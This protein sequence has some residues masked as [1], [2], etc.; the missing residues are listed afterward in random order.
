[1]K[2]SHLIIA[3][4][5]SFLIASC[6]SND[7]SENNSNG[8]FNIGGVYYNTP[9]AYINDENTQTNA[10]SDLAIILSNKDLTPDEIASGI[11]IMYVDYSGV[12]FTT[13]AKD[14]LNYRITENASRSGGFITG[15]I[16][17]LEDN[18]GSNVN[19]TQISFTINAITST[20][21]DIEFSFTREDG[22]LITGSYSGNYTNVS[23]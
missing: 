16:R 15:G 10:P 19:A 18:F 23:N 9:Y 6:S 8:G 21:L 5:F 1:M 14:L 4:L 11:N 2:K 3:I 13:G 12:D 7:D 20:T 17:L 22:T